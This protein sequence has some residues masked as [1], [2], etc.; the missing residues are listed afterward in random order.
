MLGW[1]ANLFLFLAVWLVGKKYRASF[2]FTF[3]GEALWTFESYRIER[4]DMVVLCV[5]FGVMALWNWWQWGK[6]PTE[7]QVMTLYDARAVCSILASANEYGTDCAVDLLTKFCK[8]FPDHTLSVL[9]V[10]KETFNEDFPGD[11]Q[12]HRN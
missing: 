3:V 9:A 5:V 2:L 12:T 8:R 4:T 6:A 10:W 1:I 11:V 7:V